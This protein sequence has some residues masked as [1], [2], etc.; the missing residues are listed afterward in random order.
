MSEAELD[1]AYGTGYEAV[2]YP[3]D[4][5]GIVLSVRFYACSCKAYKLVGQTDWFVEKPVD[6]CSLGHAT[7]GDAPTTR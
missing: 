3:I 7:A 1:R 5:T 2:T 4:R 6:G